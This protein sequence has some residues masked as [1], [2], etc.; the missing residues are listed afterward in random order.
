M[1]LALQ[2]FNFFADPARFGLP[3]PQTAY[4]EFFTIA[5]LAPQFLAEALAIIGND[6]YL[7]CHAVTRRYDVGRIYA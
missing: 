4:G 3:I 6:R 7:Q 1:L 2:L 5:G